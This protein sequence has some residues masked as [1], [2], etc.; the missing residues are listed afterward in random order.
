MLFGL[1]DRVAS[2][3]LRACDT[4]TTVDHPRVEAWSGWWCRN[5]SRPSG[6][7]SAIR[8]LLTSPIAPAELIA[9]VGP[10]GAGKMLI[11]YL[12]A[13]FFDPVWGRTRLDGYDPRDLSL[14]TLARAIG[15]VT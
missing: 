4:P 15:M 13:R 11:T 10:S 7:R 3:S 5:E 2:S 8:L 6:Q 12:L 1:S 14:E 9:L